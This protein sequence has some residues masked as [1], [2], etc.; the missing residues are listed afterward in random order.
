MTDNFRLNF[1]HPVKSILPLTDEEMDA[2]YKL[3]VQD[4]PEYKRVPGKIITGFSRELYIEYVVKYFTSINKSHEF[5]T[6]VIEHI[7]K[8]YKYFNDLTKTNN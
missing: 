4:H 6:R 2:I 1:N 8:K 3:I 7:D 5:N